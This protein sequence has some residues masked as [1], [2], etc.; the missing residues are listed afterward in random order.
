MGGIS[1]GTPRMTAMNNLNHLLAR[2]G[3]RPYQLGVV[4]Q[5][6]MALRSGKRRIVVYLPTG[7]GKTRVAT[8]IV[9]MAL[10]KSSGRIIVIANRKQLVKQFA[11]ALRDAGLDVGIAQGENTN[12][13]HHRQIGRAHV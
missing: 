1:L 2:I 11:D 7:G 13:L 4:D 12:G 9:L 8:A 3:L 10:A 5:T 6:R